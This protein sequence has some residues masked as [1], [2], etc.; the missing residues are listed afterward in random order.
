MDFQTLMSQ[1][2]FDQNIKLQ[3]IDNLIS[4]ID[5]QFTDSDILTAFRILDPKAFAHALTNGDKDSDVEGEGEVDEDFDVEKTREDYGQA[6]IKV[7]ADRFGYDQDIDSLAQEW[8]DFKQF[9]SD[10]WMTKSCTAVVQALTGL[11]SNAMRCLYP[12][13]AWLAEIYRVIPPHTAD[14]ER[15]FSQMKLIKTYLRNRMNEQT[16]DSI[17]RI[18]IE[19]PTLKEFPLEEAVKL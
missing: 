2:L 19:G 7:L 3:F 17:M 14:V 1:R 13:M 8:D 11:Q 15:D 5:A 9:M 16:L 6:E 12:G 4:N 10:N 18:V